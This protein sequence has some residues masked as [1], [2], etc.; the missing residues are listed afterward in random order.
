[1]YRLARRCALMTY[2]TNPMVKKTGCERR[3]RRAARRARVRRNRDS[4]RWLA[5][6]R[7]DRRLTR[8]HRRTRY[9][10]PRRLVR[11]RAQRV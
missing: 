11:H 7:W 8:F 3:V 4:M 6:C 5:V 10:P 1:M 2:R 9:R